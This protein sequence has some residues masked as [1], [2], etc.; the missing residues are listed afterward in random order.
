MIINGSRG[1]SFIKPPMWAIDPGIVA[2][3]ASGMGLPTQQRLHMPMLEGGGN[4]IYDLSGNKNRGTFVGDTK[5]VLSERGHVLEFDGA[6]DYIIVPDSNSLDITDK[7]T[8][9]AMVYFDNM[10]ANVSW[11]PIVEKRSG[12]TIN[13]EF[14]RGLGAAWSPIDELE[15]AIYNGD[16]CVYGTSGANFVIHTWYHVLVTY[17]NTTCRMYVDGQE[18][19]VSLIYGSP[20]LNMVANAVDLIIGAYPTDGDYFD[21]FIDNVLIYNDIFTPSQVATISA[22]FFGLI[23]QPSMEELWAHVAA[24]VAPTGVFYGPLIGPLG[25]PI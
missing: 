8:I 16:W 4:K 11:R 13:Y 18:K 6:G 15:F 9:S 2:C 5:W 7:I 17:D 19:S 22:D 12:S 23:R 21:G 25:G 1:S 10:T 3:N 24:G 20:S 14:R